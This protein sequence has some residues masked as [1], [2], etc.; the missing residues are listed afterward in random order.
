MPNFEIVL[1]GF[2]GSGNQDNEAL[3]LWIRAPDEDALAAFLGEIPTD[4]NPANPYQLT[5]VEC[6]QF[7]DDN[8]I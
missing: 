2:D 6:V 4:G 7:L 1:Q 8:F 3:V 5:P